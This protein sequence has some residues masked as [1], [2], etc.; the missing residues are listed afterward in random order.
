[1]GY[2]RYAT[3]E[4]VDLLNDL[5]R[6]EW[7][8]YENFFQA[9][10]KLTEKKRTGGQL[11]RK[12]AKAQTP[13]QRIMASEAVDVATKDRLRKE[14]L[15]MNPAAL[16]RMIAQKQRRIVQTARAQKQAHAAAGSEK[17][18]ATIAAPRV[19]T[20]ETIW[21]PSLAEHANVAI[22]AAVAST[23]ND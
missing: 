3:A 4:Q 16:R 17:R 1:M 15:T 5:Y 6:N 23:R 11:H 12:Y 2:Q 7:R 22:G 14:F 20:L 13:Y 8:I 21:M 9:T 18:R 10:M 19:S